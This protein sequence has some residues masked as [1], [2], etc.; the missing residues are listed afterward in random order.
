MP[1]AVFILGLAIFAQGT[2]ELMLAGLLPE[3]AADLGVSVPDAGLL[4]SA[5]AIGMLVGAP[6]LA[7]LT[8]RW[9]RRTALLTFMV[10]FALTHVAG[11]LTTSYGML[12]ATRVAGAFVYAGFW[13]VAA[14]TVVGLVPPNAR[15]RAIS[16]VVGGLTVATV[17]GLSLGT[18][19]GQHL[20]W[21]AAF[22]AVAALS[23]LAALGVLATIPG[24]RPGSAA[25]P[26]IA[27]ELRSMASPR[28][29]LAF[30]TTA[31]TTGALL[32]SFSYLSVMLV[33]TTG[34]PAAWV[35]A[36][37]ALYGVGS[38]IGI[39]IG[40]RTADARPF[41]TLYA[42]VAGLVVTSAALAMA[43]AVPVLAIPLILLLGAFGF[44]TNPA[45]NTRVF[46][47]AK[48]APTLAAAM[49]V[50]SFNVGI[51]AGPWLGGLAIGAGA[52]YPSV[53][54]IGAAL[55]VA[56]LGVVALS[57]RTRPGATAPAHQVEPV[58]GP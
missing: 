12:F 27:D 14:T 32:A 46:T 3:M 5:F 36:V 41:P 9:P 19:I 51:T 13:A 8:L 54:W 15:G 35:P 40:G 29:W 25:T 16:V 21:R 53:A 28:L 50:S 55:G 30:A 45:L 24:G 43:A 17:V 34:L 2:S 39:T 56:A 42:G 47:L 48:D 23:A 37:L 6:V 58:A 44:A 7:V 11:A 26:R 22:W 33:D 10:I 49:N 31:L 18:V 1:L 57:A 4:I 38:M 52:G 20:G